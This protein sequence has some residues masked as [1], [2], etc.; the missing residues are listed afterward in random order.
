VASIERSLKQAGADV[1]SAHHEPAS[2]TAAVG[3]S[4]IMVSDIEPDAANPRG[5]WLWLASDNLRTV[6]E[7]AVM[8]AGL[9]HK[10]HA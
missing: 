1:R 10:E 7:T 9:A 3:Q 2:N 8:I 4:G 5:V 6:A